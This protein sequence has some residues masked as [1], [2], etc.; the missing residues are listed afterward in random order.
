MSPKLKVAKGY[1]FRLILIDELG[2]VRWD[3]L[4]NAQ[5]LHPCLDH[6]LGELYELHFGEKNNASRSTV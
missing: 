4:I 6:L 5:E 3:D 1:Y 2:N